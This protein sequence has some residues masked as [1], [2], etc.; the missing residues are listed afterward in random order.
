MATVPT[1][2]Q[3]EGLVLE[4]IA[5]NSDIIS[6]MLEGGAATDKH[7]SKLN[8]N[9]S[10]NR[11][12]ELIKCELEATV[13]GLDEPVKVDLMPAVDTLVSDL[14]GKVEDL[15]GEAVADAVR[16]SATLQ[17]KIVELIKETIKNNNEVKKSI[18]DIICD[19]VK[20][21]DCVKNGVVEI[22]RDTVERDTDTKNSIMDIVEEALADDTVAINTI[23]TIINEQGIS[24]GLTEGEV[25]DVV[26]GVIANRPC[27]KEG[28]LDIVK[29][30]VNT[31]NGD[32][33]NALT[34]VM[35]NAIN[36]KHKNRL[37]ANDGTTVLGYTVN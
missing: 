13:Q 27:A 21:N 32:V 2:E 22:I 28:I 35:N 7:L 12:G 24:S 14:M 31:P 29:D 23:K 11:L 3:I 8:L 20:T 25:A 37:V 10:S 26:C 16:D 15:A 18:E 5:E 17:N 34:T 36:A 1:C 6:K 4:V 19:A 9:H 30:A 33:L